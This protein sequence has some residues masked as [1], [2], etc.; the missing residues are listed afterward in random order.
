MIEW[1]ANRLVIMDWQK[2]DINKDKKIEAAVNKISY[3][4]MKMEE[5]ER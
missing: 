5:M 2:E 1:F 3:L 4:L